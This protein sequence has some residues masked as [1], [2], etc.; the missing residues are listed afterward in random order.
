MTDGSYDA[1][2]G[3]DCRNGKSLGAGQ[4]WW[5][6]TK[7]S[8]EVRPCHEVGGTDRAAPATLPFQTPPRPSRCARAESR[9]I[10]V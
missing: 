4:V 5:G 9:V 3:P 10:R 1:A 7:G 2:Q 6:F 8:G